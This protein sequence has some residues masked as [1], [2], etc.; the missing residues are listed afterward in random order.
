MHSFVVSNR[1]CNSSLPW[2]RRERVAFARISSERSDRLGGLCQRP[3]AGPQQL[4][5]YIGRNTH[6]VAISNNGGNEINE[7][8]RNH[9]SGEAALWW[10]VLLSKPDRINWRCG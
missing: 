3:F 2:N 9:F 1:R 10:T 8:E 6:G 4:L 7:I 5:D